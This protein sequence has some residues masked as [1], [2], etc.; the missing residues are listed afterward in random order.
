D[1]SKWVG[2]C[3]ACQTFVGRP[4]LAALPLNPVVI[5]EPFQQWGLDFI[6]TLNLS[7]SVG[8]THVLIT[9]DYFTKWVEAIPVKNTTS[10]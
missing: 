9:I 1:A 4:K 10:E 3:E 2:K 8:H 6:R 5:D 7:S